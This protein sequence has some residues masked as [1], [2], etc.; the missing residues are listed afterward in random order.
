MPSFNKYEYVSLS[1]YCLLGQTF[2]FSSFEVILVD[3]CSVDNTADI[4][5]EFDPPFKFK[6]V[7]PRKNLGRSRARNLGIQLAEG[8]V[9]IFLDAEML[10]E[11]NFIENHYKHHINDKNIVVSG[12]MHYR[13]IYTFLTSDFNSKQWEHIDDF[14]TRDPYFTFPYNEYKQNHQNSNQ[15]FPL[16]TKKDIDNNSFQNLSFPN[17]Y[18]TRELNN[19]LND[20]GVDLS[21]YTLPYLAFLTGDVSVNRELLDKVG[22]FD[23]SFRG[24]GAEDWELGY[25]LYKNG[26][27]FLLDPSTFCYH[28][29]HPISS[30]NFP[31]AM[32][33]LHQF[34]KKFPE[35]DV[36][37]L[38]L[39]HKPGLSFTQMHYVVSQYNEL[40]EKHPFEYREFKQTFQTMLIKMIE[41]L[42]DSKPISNLY[43]C[44]TSTELEILKQITEIKKLRLYALTNAFEALLESK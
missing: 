12:S 11:P 8:E 22:Y 29:E 14:V 5:K 31:E 2:D 39:E 7:R 10:T 38:A 27:R 42:R 19:G 16:I 37:A 30:N 34:M 18:F 32:G 25:R 15:L 13:G 1:L 44:N 4:P 33:N 21:N 17:W 41:N 28:Q 23:E 26:A 35:I 3:D 40:C 24:Y 20:F 6:Y 36:L 43:D 9:I